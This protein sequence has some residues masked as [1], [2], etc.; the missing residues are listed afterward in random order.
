VS[1][2]S[3]RFCCYSFIPGIE[4][5][6]CSSL[7]YYVLAEQAEVGGSVVS[8]GAKLPTLNLLNGRRVVYLRLLLVVIIFGLKSLPNN[9]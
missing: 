8:I 1:S 4:D 9:I 2:S 6:C 3:Q 7:A 5:V